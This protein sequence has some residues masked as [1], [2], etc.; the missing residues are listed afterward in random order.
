[1]VFLTAKL[2]FRSLSL[3]NES[4][5]KDILSRN[6]LHAQDQW[7]LSSIFK[8]EKEFEEALNL[9]LNQ[10]A[11]QRWKQFLKNR[12]QWT[13]TSKQV[14]ELLDLC[15]NLDE[16]LSK[17]YTYVFLKHDEDLNND[18]WKAFSQKIS[19]LYQDFAQNSAWIEP[20]LLSLDENQFK[21]F[22]ESSDLKEYHFYFQTLL[23]RKAYTLSS[24]KEELIA[25]TAL[26][27][28]TAQK[29]FS[30]L[31]NVDLVFDSAKDSEGK[32]HKLTHG[33]YGLFQRSPDRTLRKNAFLN[34]HSHFFKFQNTLAELLMGH[35]Q[36]HIFEVRARG[37]QNSLMAA[38]HPKNIA[39]DVY[40]NL[41]KTVRANIQPMHD[42]IA[43]RRDLL[44]LDEIHTYDLQLPPLQTQPA[45]VDY[46]QAVEWI[47]ES[48]SPL[49]SEYQETLA[50]GL[51]SQR[52]VDRYENLNKRSGAYSSG[53]YGS[54]PY[55]LMN[56][57]GTINDVFT[58]AHE[59]G[60]SMH[61]YLSNENQPYCYARYPIFV[62][63]V[64]STFNE[65]LLM[66]YLLQKDSSEET[67]LMLLHERIEE[68]RGTLFR[69]TM[70]AEFE[71]F[72]HH[73][74]E[75]DKPLTASMINE[76]YFQLNRDYYG[77]HMQL[78]KEVAIEWARIPHFYSNFYVYQYATGISAAL[79]L[80]KK[81]LAKEPNAKESYLKF[82]SQ[83]GHSYPIDLLKI[84]GIDMASSAPIETAL[85]VFKDL[86]KKLKGAKTLSP[87]ARN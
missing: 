7:D 32:E 21:T 51:K 10:P 64:A 8:S 28:A 26:P 74:L 46:E 39:T 75:Q 24:D 66:H 59:A 54:H 27:M 25:L 67:Q 61:T 9:F 56:Y 12:G 77:P 14:K 60:H 15:N 30:L 11:D 29:T 18:I 82:L 80:A 63:E 44:G 43:V 85:N 62:A 48:V 47:I 37:Y 40:H 35:V 23:N 4:F 34:I 53:C 50:K 79:T 87:G 84:A 5:M 86:V 83:G 33:T 38:L 58:L 2:S 41:I 52:W 81:V 36:Q 20:E 49:G 57:K 73:S 31:N 22:L 45:K 6:N 78:D 16:R 68:L 55:I 76:Y 65:S 71:W 19:F 42:Y 72:I 17:L 70:F 3:R 69:Q 13:K 1:M